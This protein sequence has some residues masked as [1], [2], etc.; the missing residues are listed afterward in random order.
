[1]S[2]DNLMKAV[3]QKNQLGELDFRND[4]YFLTIDSRIEF[5]CFQANGRFYLHGIIARL[6]DSSK[7]REELLRSVMQKTIG[8]A[9]TQRVVLSVEPDNDSLALHF[10]RPLQGLDEGII[11]EALSEFANNFEYYLNL[12]N[13][14]QLSMPAMPTMIM[15]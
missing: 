5:S 1:M 6:P 3:A 13:Q 12:I 9:T 8:L 11:E 7:D 15:P 10:S 4:R 2:F 14:G